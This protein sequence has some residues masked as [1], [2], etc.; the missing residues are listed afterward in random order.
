MKKLPV[1]PLLLCLASTAFAID[2]SAGMG[3]TVGGFSATYHYGDLR[4]DE[5]TECWT[6]VPFGFS[7]YVIA[8]YGMAAIGFRANGSTRDRV[9]STAAAVKWDD[10]DDDDH[11]SGFLSFSLLGRY[12]FALGPVSGFPLAG[13]EYDLE[14]S[15]DT[16][17]KADLDQFSSP[18]RFQVARLRRKGCARGREGQHRGGHPAAAVRPAP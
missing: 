13:I 6:T 3:G 10:F 12:P 17:E 1:V 14:A 11:S 9:M 5:F 16:Q 18:P 7:P 2:L 8:T 15:M 4:F